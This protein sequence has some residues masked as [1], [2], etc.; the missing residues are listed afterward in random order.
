MHTP[1]SWIVAMVVLVIAV[2]GMAD[3]IER[4]ARPSTGRQGVHVQGEH[5]H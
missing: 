3:L 2:L 4:T 1:K 5:E